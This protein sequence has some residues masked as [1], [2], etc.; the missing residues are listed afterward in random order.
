V[1]DEDEMH[2]TYLEVCHSGLD[3]TSSPV[4]RRQRE[5]RGVGFEQ[6]IRFMVSVTEDQN[7]AEQV[8]QSFREVADGKPYV[9][10]MDLRH[11][12]IPDELIE[13]LIQSMPK[14]TGPDLDEDQQVPK[15]DYIGFMAGMIG[16]G[17]KEL[18]GNENRPHMNWSKRDSTIPKR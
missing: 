12:L 2:E 10:E 9:T 4:S 6:F 5:S 14:H 18:A 17:K 13:G 3:G 1:Y 15:Y 11:S 8:F 7:D 16:D